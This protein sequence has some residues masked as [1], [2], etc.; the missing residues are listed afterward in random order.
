MEGEKA[1]KGWANMEFA[2]CWSA[3]RQ[4]SV[5]RNFYQLHLNHLRSPAP[6]KPRALAVNTTAAI[7]TRSFIQTK[8]NTR[9]YALK[10]F[11][12]IGRSFQ[13][14][15]WEGGAD[16]GQV[17]L[18]LLSIYVSQL[19]QMQFYE[20]IFGFQSGHVQRTW[21]P[22]VPITKTLRVGTSPGTKS[23]T[24]NSLA[25]RTSLQLL[26]TSSVS[27]Q[28]IHKNHHFDRVFVF[29]F[30]AI[31]IV[32][33]VI[34]CFSRPTTWDIKLLF[35]VY[36]SLA[37]RTLTVGLRLLNK[38]QQL[39][40]LLLSALVMRDVT[41]LVNWVWSKCSPTAKS[42]RQQALVKGLATYRKS[43]SLF[44]CVDVLSQISF[45]WV[46]PERW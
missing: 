30:A 15:G 38:P 10:Q 5:C 12:G 39:H 34:L 27:D 25:M 35:L 31:V 18:K 11:S 44:K 29:C 20:N 22:I 7:T 2:K 16:T 41:N 26:A 3:R 1:N 37:P 13:Q 14:G 9:I 28:H 17:G 4:K 6:T 46:R 24:L 36:P 42:Q 32:T 33:K 21:W 40:R 19:H 8:C 23:S 43:L 45:V